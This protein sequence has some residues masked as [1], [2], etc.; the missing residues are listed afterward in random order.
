MRKRY[1]RKPSQ[2]G[3]FPAARNQSQAGTSKVWENRNEP[4]LAVFSD[5]ACVPNPGAGGWAFVVYR[6]G[7][8]TVH[9]FGGIKSATNNI[10]EL[11]ALLRA[12]EWISEYAAGETATIISDSK[13]VV[14]GCN[15]WRHSWR[16]KGWKRKGPDA[17]ARNQAIANLELWQAIDASLS[18]HPLILVAWCKGH[19]G[20]VG[21]IRA[22]ELASIGRASL[23]SHDDPAL[24][25]DREYR[26]I[27]GALV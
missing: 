13:Y 3:L 27:M 21:N 5:G 11:T 25:L 7:Q 18:A 10:A 12:L 8:E 4:A 6:D 22:D 9:D 14:D 17:T 26:A 16:A 19:A 23:D 2:L 1:F 24:A 20:T 15:I